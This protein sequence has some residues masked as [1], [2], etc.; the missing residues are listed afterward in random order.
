MA[1]E[2]QLYYDS[3]LNES[4]P[5]RV[6]HLHPL[7]WGSSFNSFREV[8]RMHEAWYVLLYDCYDVSD[9]DDIVIS[10]ILCY[11]NELD[12]TAPGASSRVPFSVRLILKYFH[13]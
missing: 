6:V 8:I 9:S 11:K 10:F 7:N 2:N 1:E 4:R 3:G 5:P 13:R 12:D